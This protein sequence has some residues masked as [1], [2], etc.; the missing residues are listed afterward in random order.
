MSNAPSGLWASHTGPA[1]LRLGE[2]LGASQ[3][4]A[5]S[6]NVVVQFLRARPEHLDPTE[7]VH[8][9]ADFLLPLDPGFESRAAGF[10]AGSTGQLIFTPAGHAHRDSMRR[11]GG[12]FVT[13]SVSDALVNGLPGGGLLP[14]RACALRAPDAILTALRLAARLGRREAEDAVVEELGLELLAAVAPDPAREAAP[15][16]VERGLALMA[17]PE[18]DEDLTISGIARRCEVHPVYFARAFRRAMGCTPSQHRARLRLLDAAL[19]IPAGGNLAQTAVSAGFADESH[20]S[21]SFR[22]AFGA[23]PG[24]F[25]RMLN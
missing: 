20:L 6:A 4:R 17:D 14:D 12:R 7:H 22:R 13:I 1:G 3:R 18:I 25:R 8:G 24:G 11:P 5:S 10:D 19:S 21:R 16:C 15:R 2:S 23:T 9:C